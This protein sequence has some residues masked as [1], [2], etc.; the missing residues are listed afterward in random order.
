MNNTTIP[1]QGN[2]GEPS[3]FFSWIRSSGLARPRDRW[4]A[5]VCGAVARELGWSV[6]LV[7]VLMVITA[8]IGGLGLVFYALGWLL[9]PDESDNAIL[10]EEMTSG[11]WDWQFIGVG[12]CV[13]LALFPGSFFLFGATWRINVGGL[14][15]AMLLFYLLVQRGVN[16][17]EPAEPPKTAGAPS[18]QAY[19]QQPVAQPDGA[20]YAQQNQDDPAPSF[21][22][23]AQS[24]VRAQSQPQPQAPSPAPQGYMRPRQPQTVRERR[25]PAGPIVVLLAVGL[26]C[27]AGAAATIIGEQWSDMGVLRGWTLALA[28]CCCVLGVILL[29]LGCMGRRAGGLH[30][31]I[32]VVMV[33]S[34]VVTITC[35]GIG[36]ARVDMDVR[37]ANYT[38]RPVRGDEHWIVNRAG[39][40][41][42]EHGVTF[43]GD[44]YDRSSINVDLTK[45]DT[46]KHEV[47][48]RD[49]SRIQSTCP[50]GT[51]NMAAINTQVVVTLP[52][53]CSAEFSKL[54]GIN[55]DIVV[56]SVG[57][58][59]IDAAY[60]ADGQTSVVSNGDS[61]SMAL[62]LPG[63]SL[64]WGSDGSTAWNVGSDSYTRALCKGIRVDDDGAVHMDGDANNSA[65][66]KAVKDGKLWPCAAQ[67]SKAT[68]H[69]ELTIAVPALSRASVAIQIEGFPRSDVPGAGA[70]GVL[71]PD[72]GYMEY[73][74]EY[75]D[76]DEGE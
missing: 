39:M 17:M 74:E 46:L 21:P 55:E 35:W 57:S 60:S 32:W 2:A 19:A 65:M 69:D 24:Q 50:A 34:L 52:E 61:G 3:K 37:V 18:V 29:V 11:H 53:G 36:Y 33:S 67:S 6:T 48:A 13:L 47:V 42:L 9:L 27:V 30:P 70:L 14:L 23:Q 72:N 45:L 15:V 51:V 16:L 38:E 49:G 68:E 25:K 28:L 4:V 26:M 64:H 22:E 7:R 63:L 12:I 1:P 75:N 8:I 54:G 40:R 76:T 66:G 10:L 58:R 43:T 20:A 59:G 41:Q 62:S 56:D 44:G 31:F 73:D 5:G 71:G